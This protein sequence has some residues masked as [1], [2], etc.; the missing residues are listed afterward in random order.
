MTIDFYVTDK[1]ESK[2]K[3][4]DNSTHLY[5]PYK[6]QSFFMNYSE[7]ICKESCYIM[8]KLDLYND[9]VLKDSEIKCLISLCDSVLN[10]SSDK[11]FLEKVNRYGIKKEKLIQ[12][13]S[14]FKNLLIYA[15]ENDKRLYAL[16]N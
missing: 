8:K 5:F 4:Y 14:S 3:S 9:V 12:F 13:I 1:Y 2:L 15:L 16:G 11:A 6:L 10:Y 7:C